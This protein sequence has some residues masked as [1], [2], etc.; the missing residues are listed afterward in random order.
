MAE[1]E[2]VAAVV[3]EDLEQMSGSNPLLVL[4]EE[5]IDS[6]LSRE[7]L[8]AI[9]SKTLASYLPPNPRNRE[10]ITAPVTLPP[11]EGER[12]VNNIE[13]R[14]MQRGMFKV[15]VLRTPRFR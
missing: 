11:S 15:E 14:V 10:R 6:E 3:A 4:S 5:T 13:R 8:S 9:M 1:T 12:R 7:A 2:V